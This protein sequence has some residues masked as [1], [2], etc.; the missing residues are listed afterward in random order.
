[1]GTGQVGAGAGGHRSRWAQ[2]LASASPVLPGACLSASLLLTDTRAET[3]SPSL[4]TL[5]S[6]PGDKKRPWQHRLIQYL[7]P[8]DTELGLSPASRAPEVLRTAPL[9]PCRLNSRPGA[10][11]HSRSQRVDQARARPAP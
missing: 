7:W 2:G 4:P 9:L 1:M 5:G 6:L 10:P 3:P 8:A 11:E